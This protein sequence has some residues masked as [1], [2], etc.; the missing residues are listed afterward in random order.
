MLFVQNRA[1]SQKIKLTG[2][3]LLTTAVIGCSVG[4]DISGVYQQLLSQPLSLNDPDFKTCVFDPNYSIV[5]FP[6]YHF[7]PTGHYNQKDFERVAHSQFQLFHTLVDYN[8]SHWDLSIFDESVIQDVYNPT[9]FQAL[10]SGQRPGDYFTRIDGK[11]FYLQ[12]RLQ[13]ANRLFGQGLPRYYEHLSHSQKN[14]SFWHG[15]H[16]YLVSSRSNSKNPQSQF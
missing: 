9:Y 16:P 4:G 15:S 7:P 12:E 11:R 10:S 3:A 2:L 5:H 6:M 1:F 14:F 13:T 8:R